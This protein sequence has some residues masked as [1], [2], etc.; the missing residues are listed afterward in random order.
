M[1]PLGPSRRGVLQAGLGIDTVFLAAPA[2]AAAAPG[3]KLVVLVLRGAMDGLSGSPPVAD[4]A[5]WRSAALSPSRR[6]RR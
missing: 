6:T 2:L 3:R 1:T 4:P 5:T